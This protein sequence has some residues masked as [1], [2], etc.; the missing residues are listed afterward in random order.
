MTLSSTSKA[1]KFDKGKAPLS[2]INRAALEA[3]ARVLEF[4]ANKYGLLNWQNGMEHRRLVDAVLRH[5][6]A[7]ADG[8]ELDPESGLS[9]LAHAR[10]GL[11]FLLYYI[12]H[13]IGEPMNRKE[14]VGEKD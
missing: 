1:N 4:G 6:T 2:L 8:E 14:G 10:S 11:G 3:E 5:V 9:H 13:N 7:Y 12:E